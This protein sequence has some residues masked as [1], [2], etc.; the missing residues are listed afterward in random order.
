M[1]KC[2]KHYVTAETL[3]AKIDSGMYSAEQRSY[4][5]RMS[6]RM[7]QIGTH[8]DTVVSRTYIAAG[9]FAMP[10]S[11]NVPVYGITRQKFAAMFR[12]LTELPAPIPARRHD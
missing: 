6:A 1:S 12:H 11:F 5:I 8:I 10:I 2:T 3:R 4:L 9:S 7:S